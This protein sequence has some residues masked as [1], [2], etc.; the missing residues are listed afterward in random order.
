MIG[1]SLKGQV[2]RDT[3]EYDRIYAQKYRELHPEINKKLCKVWQEKNLEKV[4]EINLKYRQNLRLDALNHYSNNNL[5]CACCGE[6]HIK[7]LTIDHINGNGREHRRSIGKN[8]SSWQFFMWLRKNNYPK[9]FQILC[10]NC[11]YAK[12]HG[13]CPHKQGLLRKDRR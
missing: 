1:I 3:K 9:G 13:G 4:R 2:K 10:M 5:S 12:S 6:K 8:L 11:N 7:F